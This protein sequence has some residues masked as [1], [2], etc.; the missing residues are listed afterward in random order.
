MAV[1]RQSV[2]LRTK[3]LQVHDQRFLFST[4]LLQSHSIC[5][6]LFDERMGS[7]SDSP[8]TKLLLALVSTVILGS[9]FH[10]TH[11]HI[12]LSDGSANWSCLRCFLMVAGPRYITSARTAQRTSLPTALLLL[13]S[14]LFRPLPSNDSC[15]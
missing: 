2:R 9:E 5:N 15:S 14:C 3:P 4:E 10:G 11:D 8:P 6:I 7:S 1:Y 12:L 13:R